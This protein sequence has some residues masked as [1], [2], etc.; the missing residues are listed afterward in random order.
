[1]EKL[2]GEQG[3]PLQRRNW[4]LGLRLHSELPVCRAL[5]SPQP[6][7]GEHEPGPRVCE[8]LPCSPALWPGASCVG[9]RGLVYSSVKWAPH[10]SLDNC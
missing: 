2:K 10:S 4:S 3:F 9:S 5:G 8:S 6:G 7:W 1:M